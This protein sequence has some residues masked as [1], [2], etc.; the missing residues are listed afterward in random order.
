VVVVLDAAAAVEAALGLLAPEEAFA[1]LT[2]PN[3][4]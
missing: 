2:F 4:R 3:K 1:L